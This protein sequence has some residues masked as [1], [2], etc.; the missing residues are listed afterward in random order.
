MSEKPKS[1]PRET[2]T[3]QTIEHYKRPEV[4]ETILQFCQD[5]AEWRAL[6]GDQGWYTSASNGEVRLRSPEDYENTAAKFRTL[7]ATLDLF[8]PEVKKISSPWDK[9][10]GK[11]ATPIGTFRDCQAYTLGAD[12]D[13]IGNIIED[14]SIKKAVEDAAKFLVGMLNDAGISKSV[15]C[16]Y[17]GGGAY[18]LIHHALFRAKSEW[19]PEEREE[20]F[21]SLTGSYNMFLADVEAKFFELHPEHRGKVKIDKIN[22]QKRKFK[23]IFSIH[24]EHDLAVVPL[25]PRNIKIDFEQARLP[26]S[27]DVLREGKEW[28]VDYDIEEK[29][30]MKK[31]LAPY[32]VLVKEDL[33]Q[34]KEL[35]GNHEIFR[36]T[37]PLPLDAWPPCMKNILENCNSGTGP[38]RACAVL[39]SY[40]YQA[41]YNESEALKLWLPIAERANVE[42]RIFDCWYGSMICPKCSKI[43]ETSSGYPRPGLGGL[44]YCLPDE[45]CKICKWPVNYGNNSEL[46]MQ[47]ISDDELKDL[48][49]AE[50]P[51]LEIHLEPDNLIM[52][53]IE[54]GKST[55]DAYPEY[56]YGMALVLESI[57]T[58]R[59]LVLKLKQGDVFPNVWLFLLGRST[60]SRK[61]AAISKGQ[62]ITESLFQWISLPQSYSPE[63][64]IE[65][66][67]EK[68]RAYLIKDEAG[69]M[70]EAMQ[71]NYM[72]EMRDLYCVLYDCQSYSR[73]LRKG[74]RKEKT[75]F[76]IIKPFINIIC[77]T[78]PETFREYTRLLDL[79]SGWL[80]RFLFIYP[81][82]RKD[83]MPFKPETGEDFN[84]YGEIIGRIS[85]VKHIFFERDDPIKITLTPEA[86]NYYQTWQEVRERELQETT[87]SIELGLWGRL[88]F[89]ALKLAVLFTVGRADYQEDV[90]VSLEHVREAC[91]QIDEYF[92]HVGML[93]A[94]EVAREETTNLQNK[95]L[96]TVSRNGG[97]IKKRDLLKKLHVKLKDVDEALDALRESEEIEL[98]ELQER[99]GTTIWVISKQINRKEK[100]EIKPKP[101]SETKLS[102]VS[103]LSQEERCRINCYNTQGIHGT[104]ATEGTPATPE[105]PEKSSWHEEIDPDAS[106][107]G[108]HPRR[109]QPTPSSKSIKPKLGDACPVCG[110][111]IGPGQSSRTFEG[112]SYCTSC[113]PR[114]SLLRLSVRELTKKNGIAPTAIEIYEDVTS[115]GG[116]PPKKDFV[117]AMLRALGFAEKDGRWA[118]SSPEDGDAP[119]E[120]ADA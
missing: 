38:H 91:R 54:Y 95:I 68:A 35:S 102:Q 10:A 25:D 9:E 44:E 71:K 11:P 63:G 85:K 79:T 45:K 8:D 18:V 117:S 60:I 21:R 22:N 96:G 114:L 106:S 6:N 104:G 86:W 53:Y 81:T 90:Q 39:A 66:L 41:G 31:L 1:L 50:N 78:T 110:V 33:K 56:H 52:R 120:R 93:V 28:Y 7:Y 58:N 83:W 119:A 16:L 42:T 72:L 24:K 75:E 32:S 36:R 65:E 99:G 80:L 87:N 40:L 88:S 20:S 76:N 100:S 69:A 111:D 84:L 47:I 73:K 46:E 2:A 62:M 118:S 108:P 61:S 103:K 105:T 57:A 74:Q 67:S 55:C 29:E 23:C 101:I 48:H 14:P 13:G 4:R 89:Y 109:D 97:K 37:E 34:R 5:G 70:L 17:S 26:L 43:R 116:R 98:L 3:D 51:R 112:V 94:E 49:V 77:A 82:Y 19:S 30:A 64:M 107:L 15:H 12:I 115:K 92:L 27:D 59:N 113:P